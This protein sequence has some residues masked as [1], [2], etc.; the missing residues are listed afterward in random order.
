MQPF[1]FQTE[2]RALFGALH[3]AA[4]PRALLLMCPPLFHEHAR[5]YRFFS[6]LADRFAQDGLSC[7]RFD[8]YGTGDSAGEDAEFDPTM[9]QRDIVAAARE[10]RARAGD[11]PLVLMGARGSALLASAA[12]DAA[13]AAA[14]WLWQ[15]E[16]DG[17]RYIGELEHQD[18]EARSD[19]NRYPGRALPRPHDGPE[20]LG[21]RVSPDLRR[22]LSACRLEGMQPVPLAVIA[23]PDD[24]MPALALASKHRLPASVS[25]WAGEIDLRSM[26]PVRDAE[27]VVQ[28][29]L[30]QLPLAPHRP[31]SEAAHG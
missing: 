13:G 20:L 30:T 1:Y 19:A 8:Y 12:A 15:P 4:A 11:H 27:Q 23:G 5:S 21:F 26:I 24:P 14:L 25:D 22:G 10:L 17:A 6:Q 31:L 29:L 28:A 3:R 16:T 9:A 7:L 2:G 18:L